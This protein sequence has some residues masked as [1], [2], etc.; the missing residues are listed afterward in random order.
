VWIVLLVGCAV[1]P[2]VS[3]PFDELAAGVLQE[4]LEAP[5]VD[6]GNVPVS[7]TKFLCG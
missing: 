3:A 2:A 4:E 5:H 6:A 7:G 1:N